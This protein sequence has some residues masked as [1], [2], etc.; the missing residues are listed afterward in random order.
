MDMLILINPKLWI[1][2]AAMT[3]LLVGSFINVLVWRLPRMLRHEWESQAHLVLGQNHAVQ[4]PLDL[5]TPASHCPSCAKPLRIRDLVPVLSFAWLK[6]RCAHCGAPIAWRYPMVE[7]A[8][9]AVWA[10]CAAHWGMGLDAIGNPMTSSRLPA[11]IKYNDGIYLFLRD[12]AVEV[13]GCEPCAMLW[14]M[15]AWLHIQRCR[16][17][18]TYSTIQTSSLSGASR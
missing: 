16:R 1:S 11:S 12:P 4:A 14:W 15:V 2:L 13:P 7:L 6:G 5:F 8:V 9:A 3:G 17:Q 10:F 18:E